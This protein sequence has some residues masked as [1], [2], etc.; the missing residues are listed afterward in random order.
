MY[1]KRK[2]VMI[3]INENHSDQSESASSLSVHELLT[4]PRIDDIIAKKIRR[5]HITD[6]DEAVSSSKESVLEKFDEKEISSLD[7]GIQFASKTIHNTVRNYSRSERL[8]TS[9]FIQAH[10]QDGDPY[11][12]KVADPA[13]K[14][15]S[16]HVPE[17]NGVE[18]HVW[19]ALLRL[20]EKS[21]DILIAVKMNGETQAAVAARLNV[22]RQQVGK[23]LEKAIQLLREDEE[24]LELKKY[25]N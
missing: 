2:M 9:R 17:I 13:T 20:D 6:R 22:S 23:D 11:E 12:C 7:E 25:Y 14:S 19:S 16:Y 21:R 24:I 4:H 18:A 5:Y 1:N 8:R 3:M 10:E 15:E